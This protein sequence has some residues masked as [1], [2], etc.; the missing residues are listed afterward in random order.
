MTDPE[1]NDKQ[2]IDILYC[3]CGESRRGDIK[4]CIEQIAAKHKVKAQIEEVDLCRGGAAHDLSDNNVVDAL[5]KDL[6][7]KSK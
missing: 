7:R 2:Q 6:K 3:Y 5:K 4:D 1:E